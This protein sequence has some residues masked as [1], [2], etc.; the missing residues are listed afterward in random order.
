MNQT[1]KAVLI[2]R[3][4]SADVMQYR[5][6][7]TPSIDSDQVL[8]RV[9]AAGVNPVDWKM[10]Q[11]EFRFLPL[12]K[13]PR[14]VGADFAGEVVQVGQKVTAYQPGDR[15]YGSLSPITGGAYAERV[16]APSGAIAIQP[17]SISAEEAAALPIAGV[18]ALQAL[19]DQ[20]EVRAGQSV[21]INGASG[22]VGTFAVQI[23][24]SM[25]AT[26]TAVCS[27]SNFDLVKA[28][29]ADYTL[30]YRQQDFAKTGT[31]YDVIFDAAG[32][33]TFSDCRGALTAKGRYVSTLPNP[34]VIF[35]SVL[36]TILP[37]QSSKLIFVQVNTTDLTCLNALIDQEKLRVILA[38]SYPLAD[39]QEAHRYSES[40]HPSGKIVLLV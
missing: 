4:G 23:A 40:E 36:T 34:D 12:G 9:Q 29:G 17:P 38:R 5:D 30:D 19:R 1:M 7:E 35:W 11:G 28:L 24:K 13:M 18:T 26:V 20:G 15:V 33:R 32:K 8:V 10:R 16:A 39:A 22:G 14:I 37:G 6:V 25:G 31:A 21:L 27:E 3:Y 2:D